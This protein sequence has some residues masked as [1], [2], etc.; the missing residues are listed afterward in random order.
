MFPFFCCRFT[1]SIGSFVKRT[2]S[3]FLFII[4]GLQDN[5]LISSHLSVVS[6]SATSHNNRQN[7]AHSLYRQ[8]VKQGLA[9]YKEFAPLRLPLL[10]KYHC[11]KRNGVLPQTLCA[12]AMKVNH[13]QK[14]L[15]LVHDHL[16]MLMYCWDAGGLAIAG[17]VTRSLVPWRF[18]TFANYHLITTLFLVDKKQSE[19]GG[20]VYILLSRHHLHHLLDPIH[21]LLNRSIGKTTF[22]DFI[23]QQ[24]NKLMVHGDLAFSNL[25]RQIQ[26]VP[27]NR[28]LALRFEKLFAE[29]TREVEILAARIR[30]ELAAFKLTPKSV[31]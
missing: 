10:F 22:G 20:A 12:T 28:Q 27:K 31:R 23:R 18:Y 9:Y 11:G 25:P 3:T 5:K 15:Q 30:L 16:S 24:R 21:S 26:Q 2:R 4:G 1:L 13:K 19:M 8:E 17:S 6:P 14:D 7:G 29:L